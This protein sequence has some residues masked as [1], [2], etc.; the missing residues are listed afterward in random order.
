[1][2]ELN[3]L[4]NVLAELRPLL[5]KPEEGRTGTENEYSGRNY[6]VEDVYLDAESFG[7]PLLV[8]LYTSEMSPGCTFGYRIAAEDLIPDLEASLQTTIVWA[9]FLEHVEGS[10]EGLPKECSTEAINWTM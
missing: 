1:M 10:A 4:E 7:R 2:S 6:R 3:S 9:N 5:L 8:I